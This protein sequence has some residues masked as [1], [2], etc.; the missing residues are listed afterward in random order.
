MTQAI[1]TNPDLQSLQSEVSHLREELHLRDQLIEQLSQELFK[2]VKAKT[3]PSPSA[4]STNNEEEVSLL[5]QQLEEIEEQVEFYQQQLSLRDEDIYQLRQSVGELKD[6]STMLEMVVQELPHIY[7][8]KFKE[9]LVPI[10]E[11]LEKLQ[12]ENRQLQGE[13]QSL[14]YRL[15]IKNRRNAN[16]IEIPD[17]IGSQGN[18]PIPSFGS[19]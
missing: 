14:T 9:R 7:R 6:R 3:E 1:S 5:H 13:V 11:K 8:Q 17:L 18:S 15:A 4:D 19:A 16:K 2:L 12:R 10:R